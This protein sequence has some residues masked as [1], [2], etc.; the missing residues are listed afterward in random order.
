[1]I[2]T[3]R[4]AT[5]VSSCAM[6]PS[7]SA[8]DRRSLMRV[9][10]QTVAFLGERPRASAFGIFVCAIALFG[11]GGRYLAGAHGGQRHLIRGEQLQ[12]RH[13]AGDDDDEAGVD[14]GCEEDADE[15][16]VD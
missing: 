7:S 14:A 3:S 5:C 9:V 11:F 12:Q 1:M 2:I 16:D 13:A 15:H 8:G 4:L 10:A 6:T